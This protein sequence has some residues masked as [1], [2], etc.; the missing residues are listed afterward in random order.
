MDF[1]ECDFTTKGDEFKGGLFGD[2]NYI[3]EYISSF[4]D[5]NLTNADFSGVKIYILPGYDLAIGSSID[6]TGAKM[7]GLK[8]Y[9]NVESQS[10]SPTSRTKMSE[11]WLKQFGWNKTSSILSKYGK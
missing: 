6:F 2:G 10:I 9:S 7:D 3:L 5:C 8:L 4:R 11:V 1:K